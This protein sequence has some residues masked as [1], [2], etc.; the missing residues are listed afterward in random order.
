MTLKEEY[1][2]AKAAH[3]AAKAAKA[4]KSQSPKNPKR[5]LEY[6]D[7]GTMYQGGQSYRDSAGRFILGDDD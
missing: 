5:N 7:G 6:Q 4:A 1:E 2:I 3:F